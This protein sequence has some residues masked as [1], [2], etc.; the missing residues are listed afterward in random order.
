VPTRRTGT[1]PA[2]LVAVPRPLLRERA[3]LREGDA[4]L[5]PFDVGAAGIAHCG[6]IVS[7]TGK[8]QSN[9]TVS[10]AADLLRAVAA[11][12]WVALAFVAVFAL[13]KLVRTQK[14]PLTKLGFGPSGVTIEFAEA[15]LSEA[16]SKP[17]DGGQVVVGE[18][19]QRS[20]IDRLRSHA[21]LLGRARI[22]W[23]D[24]HPENNTPIAEL[25]RKFGAIIDTPRSNTEA[26]AL[27]SASRYDVI[28]SDVG[29]GDEGAGS[30]LKGVELANQVYERWGQQILLFTARFDPAR[31]PD[32]TDQERLRLVRDVERSVFA[33]TNRYDEALHYVLDVLER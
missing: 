11:L 15:K 33:R 19:A 8:E 16:V 10:D 30:D 1:L 18:A 24:D 26:L 9:T 20:V 32:V 3:A 13:L 29:R 12:S 27:L 22:L 5:V 2:L 21:D 25:L 23:V 31:L 6:Y 4:S 28:I 14:S 7:R 17:S